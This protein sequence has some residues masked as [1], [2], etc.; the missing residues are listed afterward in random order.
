MA[1][2]TIT[3]LPVDEDLEA[4]AAYLIRSMLPPAPPPPAP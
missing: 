4:R 2:G 3:E 1:D